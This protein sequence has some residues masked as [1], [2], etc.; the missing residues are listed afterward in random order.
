MHKLET[1]LSKLESKSGL[2]KET[3]CLIVRFVKTG[4]ASEYVHIEG[5]AG[6]SVERLTGETEDD[7]IER[8]KGIFR[9]RLGADSNKILVLRMYQAE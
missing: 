9:N 7:F 8:A 2:Q 1:R 3:L 6:D 4:G 5:N